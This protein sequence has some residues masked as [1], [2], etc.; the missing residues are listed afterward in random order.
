V[1]VYQI[2]DSASDL[3]L[4]SSISEVEYIIS[5][6]IVDVELSIIYIHKFIIQYNVDP[7]ILAIFEK[8]RKDA[9]VRLYAGEQT[10]EQLHDMEVVKEIREIQSK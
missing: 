6:K 4:F 5:Q 3:A 1:R 9:V 8:M 10:A 2:S 7:Q